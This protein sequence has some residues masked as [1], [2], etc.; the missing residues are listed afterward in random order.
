MLV[1]SHSSWTGLAVASSTAVVYDWGERWL[2]VTITDSYM[3]LQPSHLDK[4]C[5]DTIA[6][7]VIS[8]RMWF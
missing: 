5:V 3:V 1:M 4:R 2:T 6:G 7:A 8:P